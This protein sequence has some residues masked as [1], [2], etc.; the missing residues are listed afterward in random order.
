MGNSVFEKHPRAI[1]VGVFGVLMLLIGST[2]F[3]IVQ[4]VPSET[5]IETNV[6]WYKA[7]GTTII[8]DFETATISG[9]IKARVYFSDYM[10]T[11]S[12]ITYTL[13]I[14]ICTVHAK[15]G[16]GYATDPLK[17]WDGVVN[18]RTHGATDYWI[19]I[20][21]S[22]IA[23]GEYRFDIETS[24]ISTTGPPIDEVYL[25]V[26]ASFVSGETMGADG[27]G[28]LVITIIIVVLVSIG[29]VFSAKAGIF[30]KAMKTVRRR[31]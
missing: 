2:Y 22:Q 26:Y 20:D 19:T 15:S 28:S 8:P 31:A 18:Q 30:K 9:T 29:L 1:A 7:D 13:D 3:T 17:T 10:R 12:G 23:D 25:S 24:W 27:D 14:V 21:T 5:G 6:V 16:T 4:N 11:V